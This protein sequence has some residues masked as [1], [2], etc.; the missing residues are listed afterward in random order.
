MKKCKL[1][2]TNYADKANT[3]YLTDGII[4]SC[5]NEE[6][7][8]IREKGLMFNI[9]LDNNYI[10]AKFQR[11][12]SQ[13]AIHE[14]FGR[15]PNDLEIEEAKHVPYSVDYVFC[16]SCEKR[17]TEM[18]EPFLN[19]ILP[20]L[21]G[22]NLDG[23]TSITFDSL[24]VRKFFLLQIYRTAICDPKIHISSEKL[25]RLRL[26]ILNPESDIE[27]V[28]SIAL[29]VSH[30]NTV[31]GSYEYTKNCVGTASSENDQF[32]IFNDF[33]IHFTKNDV[34]PQ[35][36]SFW[37]LNQKNTFY[38]FINYQEDT[39]KIKILNNT[40]RKQLWRQYQEYKGQQQKLF[41]CL[42]FTSR[43]IEMYGVQ[44]SQD[45]IEKFGNAI[46]YGEEI[47][48]ESKYSY[49][50]IEKLLEIYLNSFPP[51]YDL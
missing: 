28:K 43:Y 32:I 34:A 21:R 22:E 23:R 9:S 7:S 20:Q 33:I 24:I 13:Q 39:F 35:F 16:S 1:C 12:T 4:R 38:D 15:D 6:G 31:G 49:A 29:L 42:E 27:D 41:Y 50:R 3:H 36:V 2:L 48:D 26:I 11:N 46:I 19:A 10:E 18:E 47:K 5:L 51:F 40:E 14:T 44:P 37:G 45:Y 30:L 8:N 25:E 17:F